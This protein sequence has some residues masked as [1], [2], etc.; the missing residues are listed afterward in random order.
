MTWELAGERALERPGFCA[1]K[2]GV[3]FAGTAYARSRPPQYT[4]RGLWP[5]TAIWLEAGRRQANGILLAVRRLRLIIGD[6]RIEIDGK[7][8]ENEADQL[9]HC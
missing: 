1:P 2:A 5:A 6:A 9:F 3:V 8:F 4:R 7:G